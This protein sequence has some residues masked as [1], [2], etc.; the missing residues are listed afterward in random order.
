[1]S[2]QPQRGLVCPGGVGDCG[3]RSV[4]LGAYAI[5]LHDEPNYVAA[6]KKLRSMVCDRLKLECVRLLPVG[7]SG[8]TVEKSCE[9]S[10]TAFDR[11][12]KKEDWT[13][14][15]FVAKMRLNSTCMEEVAIQASCDV[16]QVTIQACMLGLR[17]RPHRAP[18]H[19]P[20]REGFSR[21]HLHIASAY[22]TSTLFSKWR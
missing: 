21:P 20:R 7:T 6:G 17:P 5:H 16:L 15:G 22:Q 13:A 3:S 11:H 2:T 14:D 18:V 12:G 10:V 9:L 1:M 4:M 19:A 8:M